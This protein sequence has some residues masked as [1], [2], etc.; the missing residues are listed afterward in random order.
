MIFRRTL[1][2][3]FGAGA[4]AV[5]F[6]ALAQQ[7]AA[8]A[9]APGK[10]WRAGILLARTRPA[11]LE[12]DYVS[13]FV[14]RMREL[15]YVEGKNFAIEWRFADGDLARLPTLAAQLVQAKVD[16]ILANGNQAVAAA[17]GATATIPIVMGNAG[18]PVGAGF[19]QSLA[20]PGRNITGLSTL[21]VDISAKYLQLLRDIAPK[22]TRVAVMADPAN[23]AT[24]LALKNIRAAG[25]QTGVT[26]IDIGTRNA[27]EIDS[28]FARM[29][30]ARAQGFIL[31]SS[32]L[33]MQHRARVAQLALQHRLPFISAYR[34]YVD[35]GG[36]MS[37]GPS[38]GGL[39]RLSATYVDKIF[40]G[41]KPAD[42]PVQQP[43][44]IEMYINGKTAKALGLK[45]PQSLLISADKV[46]E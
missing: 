20:R 46:I 39:Y 24:A 6:A 41:A 17:M 45:L 7:P 18:D 10:I 12:D 11:S 37:Y 35:A 42:L 30:K 9:G 29:Q 31:I 3:A 5:P 23:V 43:T 21:A 13:A 15:G 2:Q 36:L 44:I 25:Q 14:K 33:F 4:L 1:L 34:E 16:V 8:S 27:G 19:V 26:M 40:K 22:L 28:A 32:P 38:L